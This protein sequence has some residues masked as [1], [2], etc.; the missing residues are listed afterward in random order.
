MLGGGGTWLIEAFKGS[1]SDIWHVK[2]NFN[3]YGEKTRIW[4]VTYGLTSKNYNQPLIKYPPLE[5]WHKKL[6]VGIT[7]IKKFAEKQSLIQF[8]DIFQNALDNIESDDPLSLIVH[9]DLVIPENYELKAKQIFA[10]CAKAWIVAMVDWNDL[11][12]KGKIQKEYTKLSDD[13]Y[14]KICRAIMVATN[15]SQ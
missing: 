14:L 15:S 9:N 3:P 12:F 5:D 11:S 7:K 8:I 2:W 6:I 1:V 13:L 4:S 10:A